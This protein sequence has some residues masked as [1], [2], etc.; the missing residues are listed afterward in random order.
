MPYVKKGELDLMLAQAYDK[1]HLIGSVKT[2]NRVQAVIRNAFSG[3][4]QPG[5]RM[6]NRLHNTTV[7]LAMSHTERVAQ[8]IVDQVARR[9]AVGKKVKAKVNGRTLR[10]TIS[11]RPRLG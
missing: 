4:S 3:G 6:A 11:V 1:G 5:G 7:D 8:D 9:V 2:Y 10:P